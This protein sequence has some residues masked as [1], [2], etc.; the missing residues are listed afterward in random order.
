MEK[1]EILYKICLD[2]KNI[3]VLLEVIRAEIKLSERSVPKCASMMRDI[4]KRNIKKLS[5]PPGDKEEFRKIVKYLNEICVNEII[6]IIAKK[7]PD[8]QISKR[9]QVSREQMRRDR[10]VWGDRPNHVPE[11]PHTRS[12]REYDDD[13]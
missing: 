12:R 5:R 2:D 7:Y 11:R 1:I 8:L 3:I 13:E 6:E 4:M 10:D 9:V